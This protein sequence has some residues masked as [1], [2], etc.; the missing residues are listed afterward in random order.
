MDELAWLAKAPWLSIPEW[1]DFMCVDRSTVSRRVAGWRKDGLV[2]CRKEGRLLRPRDRFILST[3]G[4]DNLFPDRHTHPGRLNHTHDPLDGFWNHG[5][6]SYFNGYAGG[7]ALYQRL[8]LIETWYPLAPRVLQGD[9]AAWT[10]DGSGRRILSWRW[11]RRTRLIHALGTYEDD[12]KLFFCYI[13]R[14]LTVNML[15]QRWETRF[16]DVRGLA[17]MSRGEMQERRRDWLLEPPDPDVD[18]DPKPSA[19]VITTPDYRG[20]ELALEVLPEDPAYLYVVGPPED[21]QLIY[22][23]RA[24]PAPHDDVVDQFEDVD[25][26]I[27]Q[28]LCR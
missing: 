10:Y 19:Y 20:V 15:R 9:G 17:T 25:L 14:S 23:N 24:Y 13:G 22:K 6:P 11:L 16:R 12:Y 7:L 5:H 21:R 28:D 27:P 2:A 8:E 18:Y 26:G 1:A 4:L 3:A